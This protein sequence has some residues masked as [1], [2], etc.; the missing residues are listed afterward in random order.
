MN[1]IS[2][3]E[4]LWVAVTG[5]GF[6]IALLS[7]FATLGDLNALKASGKNGSRKIIAVANVRQ[8]I[9]RMIK[10]AAF[11][12][13]GII[14]MFTP[15]PISHEVTLLNSIVGFVFMGVAILMVYSSFTDYYD[16]KR[17]L[18]KIE[19]ELSDNRIKI[20]KETAVNR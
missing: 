11:V 18:R 12:S 8:E 13:V 19:A 15:E 17:L 1:N 5:F 20:Y 6:F 16:R 10:Q 14:A 7:F 4:V 3:V 2:P 9:I